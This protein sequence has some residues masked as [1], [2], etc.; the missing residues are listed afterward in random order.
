MKTIQTEFG[1][2][3]EWALIAAEKITGGKRD[4]QKR[5]KTEH[6]MQ[7]VIGIA[8]LIERQLEEAWQTPPN[9]V[10]IPVRQWRIDPESKPDVA[11][12]V[13]MAD[14]KFRLS[15]KAW[16]VGNNSGD[17]RVLEQQ[18]AREQR[19]AGEGEA[20]LAP[21]GI[22]CDWPGL[23]PSFTV[24]GYTELSTLGAVLSALGKPRNWL[25]PEDCK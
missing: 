8:A 17:P 20:M 6:G 21:L 15:A 25:K 19:L 4:S 13:R 18:S 5:Y 23:Y 9:P 7:T 3:K 2:R 14:A 22:K 1:P 16:E 10:F 11:K 24:R 12:L